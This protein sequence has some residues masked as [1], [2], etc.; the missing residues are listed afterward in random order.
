[1]A[2][3]KDVSITLS[4]DEAFIVY[5][6]LSMRLASQRRAFNAA[7]DVGIRDAINVAM[8]RTEALL[9]KFRQS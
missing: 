5:E 2:A 9:V 4:V 7:K 6:G 8:A 1:M 3:T